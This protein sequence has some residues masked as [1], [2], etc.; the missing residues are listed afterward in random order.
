MKRITVMM[1]LCLVLVFGLPVFAPASNFTEEYMQTAVGSDGSIVSNTGYAEGLTSSAPFVGTGKRESATGVNYGPVDIEAIRA[2]PAISAPG[3]IETIIGADNRFR[4]NPI[5]GGFAPRQTV[6][7]T[8]SAGRCSGFLIGSNTVITAGHCVHP[9]G[10]G[11]F[12]PK[13][14]YTIYPG[15]TGTS[16]PWGSCTAKSLHSVIGW[17]SSG[18]AAHDYGAIKL[19]CTVG[20]TVGWFGYWWTSLSSNLLNQ[21]TVI[22]GYPGDKPLTQW[23][24]VDQVRIVETNQLAYSNDT[25]G[26]VSGSPVW[27]DRPPG[28]PV[29]SNGRYV[30]AIHAYGA[31]TGSTV[32]RGTRITQLVF[33]NLTNW[34]NLP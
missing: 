14:S 31:A 21:N 16:A 18:L 17:T 6:L 3:S 19:N 28:A 34:R 30:M 33:N 29:A 13:A 25:V 11:S 8:F 24:S 32:N 12:Y 7:I 9:G 2:L 20:N 26:G 27:Q 4:V 15:Y 23:A 10:G 22:T 1:F 5:S